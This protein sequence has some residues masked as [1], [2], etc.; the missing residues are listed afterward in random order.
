MQDNAKAVYWDALQAAQKEK[1]WGEALSNAKFLQTYFPKDAEIQSALDSINGKIKERR[2][3]LLASFISERDEVQD[4]TWYTPSSAPKYVND[5]CAIYP[6]L[7]KTD[8]GTVSLRLK[9]VYTGDN[10]LFLSGVIFD[11]DGQN[12]LLSYAQ[13]DYYR[14]NAWGD[15]WEVIDKEANETDKNL[16]RSVANSEKTIIRFQGSLYHYDMTVSQAEKKAIQDTLEL[17]EYL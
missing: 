1:N 10:W 16:L 12:N 8:S 3:Q 17:A 6:Y 5:R 15:V 7:S 14:D 9:V 11:I 2:T 4:L 13:G